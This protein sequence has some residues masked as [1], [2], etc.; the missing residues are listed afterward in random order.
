MLVEIAVVHQGILCRESQVFGEII[1]RASFVEC[2]CR[3]PFCI[4]SIQVVSSLYIH[5]IL[6]H[7]YNPQS[8]ETVSF[9]ADSRQIAIR[10]AT[11]ISVSH[12]FGKGIS[13]R[14]NIFRTESASLRSI[15]S[16]NGISVL[17]QAS[18]STSFFSRLFICPVAFSGIV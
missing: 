7:W 9:I 18:H 4:V 3:I 16:T 6:N 12:G 10:C 1:I 15:F 17:G 13:S 8:V 2:F 11:V 5:F 14:M